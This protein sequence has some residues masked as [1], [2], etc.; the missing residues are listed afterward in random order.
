MRWWGKKP[1]IHSPCN[2]ASLIIRSLL[3]SGCP[4][5]SI[6]M[7]HKYLQSMSILR[8]L[9]TCLFSG[10]PNQQSLNT[11]LC[12][13]LSIQAIHQKQFMNLAISYS[14][15]RGQK[16]Y[17][18]KFCT[19]RG[20]SFTTVLQCYP[21]VELCY[22]SYLLSGGTSMSCRA[23]CKPGDSFSSLVNLP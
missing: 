17:G 6:H 7:R 18:S 4:L 5:V 9:S 15:Q 21:W 3:Y 14:R 8:G 11:V 10:L 2:F 12:K 1:G 13:S 20:L 22:C 23:T 19:P 16:L